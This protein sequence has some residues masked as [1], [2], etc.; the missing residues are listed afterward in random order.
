MHMQQEID[1]KGFINKIVDQ[2][3]HE[4]DVARIQ[5]EQNKNFTQDMLED[6]KFMTE[7]CN[8]GATAQRNFLEG[9]YP[10]Q[11]IYSQDLYAMIR[12]FKPSNKALLNDAAMTSNWIDEQKKKD[13]TRWVIARDWDVTIHSHA[14]FG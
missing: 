12:R 7:H 3:N 9:K 10:L 2:H 5:F 1:N 14:C 13:D 11:P 8:M 6:V 4:L